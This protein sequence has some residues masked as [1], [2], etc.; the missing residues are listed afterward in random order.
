MRR[1]LYF[2]PPANGD[3]GWLIIAFDNADE[4]WLAGFD[5]DDVLHSPRSIDTFLFDD[6][7]TLT[8]AELATYTFVV[9]GNGNDNAL[10][11]TNLGDRL[12]GRDGD[13]TLSAGTG[14]D[15]LTGGT[16]SD[17][18]DGGAG[19]DTYALNLG[20]GDDR[21]IDASEDGN[22]NTI[23][24]G[25]GISRDGL[26]FV[27]EGSSMLLQYG[28]LGDQVR[29]TDFHP[30][31]I[32]G[33]PVIDTFLFA[34]GSSANYQE[35]INPAPQGEGGDVLP[36]PQEKTDTLYLK[37]SGKAD[38]RFGKDGNA[39]TV[40]VRRKGSIRVNGY[41][42][43]SDQGIQ[44]IETKDGAV[45]LATDHSFDVRSW[46]SVLNGMY[47]GLF[48]DKLQISGLE[49]ANMLLGAAD[50][51]VIFGFGGNDYAQGLQ[52]DDLLVGG[53]GKD[54]L[55]GNGGNDT[56]YGD[57]DNDTLSG[58]AGDDFLLGG[59]GNDTLDGGSQNDHL[60][61]GEGNDLLTGGSGADTFVF[62][63]VLD[64]LTNAD[65]ITDFVAGEDKVE[66]DRTIFS[67]LAEEGSLF[68]EYFL[69]TSSGIAGDA[70]DYLLYNTATGALLYDTDGNG[71]GIAVE[72][73]NLA[74]TPALTAKD[75]IIA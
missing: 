35:F 13:D 32:G 28:P 72:F 31:Q 29:M 71:Q 26:V 70:N 39:L 36:L 42:G 47:H 9:E 44:R 73:A 24:F 49:N 61:G 17:R 4:V 30:T 64:E 65:T 25:E 11:G 12:Y 43:A 8:F 34:D 50:D 46:V 55:L 20:D 18:M 52:G 74:T 67:A 15:V 56:V 51:D 6:G 38:L 19:R 48:G 68:S 27:M 10:F 7:T 1:R 62:D 58:G 60:N 53:K 5:P 21:I 59:T 66:L 23:L 33:S 16:G 14:D 45:N 69:A 75:F 57:Q 2:E 37:D 54:Q 22:G 63:T 41:F 3:K 40:D